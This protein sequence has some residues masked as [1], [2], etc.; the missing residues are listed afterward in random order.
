M[1]FPSR[2]TAASIAVAF[3]FWMGTS[4]RADEPSSAQSG[5]DPLINISVQMTLGTAILYQGFLQD[6]GMP[7]SGTY[8]FTFLLFDAETVGGQVGPTAIVDDAVVANGVFTVPLD[9]GAVFT[10]QELW[11]ET[12]VRLGNATDGHTIL[13][14]R[15]PLATTP[16][17]LTLRPGARIE[18]N[19]PEGATP[20]DSAALAV[21]NTYPDL[22]RTYGIY[23]EARS[24]ETTNILPAAV[25]GRGLNSHA[26]RGEAGDVT[27]L[28]FP[29]GDIGIVGL[30]STR[31]I[32]G[33]TSA[34]VGV[35]GLSDSNYGVWGISTEYRGV[36]GR[37]NRTDNN[38]GLYTPDNLYTLNFNGAGAILLVALNGGAEV[39]EPGEVVAVSG[40]GVAIH[41]GGPPVAAVMR[42]T[43]ENAEAII[44]VAQS[45]FN[46]AAV[47]ESAENPDDGRALAAM[48]VTPAGAIQPGEHMLLV[49]RGPAR[50][51]ASTSAGAIQ[52]G[53]RLTVSGGASGQAA[54]ALKSTST[55]TIGKAMEPLT[56]GQDQ[57]YV[58]INVP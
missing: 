55:A 13:T 20:A 25:L 41:K 9:F 24:P 52:P 43:A 48:D 12:R 22:S 4:S 36:T 19:I 54:R 44:G 29:L 50:V 1:T 26:I 14:P 56:D 35:Y 57:I 11:L 3:I 33:S 21:I 47:D 45:R 28:T 40:M 30:G 39:I 7:A 6:G 34:G 17:A 10:G 31:G 8:D 49:V 16:A 5:A 23:A 27:G 15:Q 58:F 53:M 46:A 18:G 2:Q 32:H 37:T 38:F 42:A 51:K